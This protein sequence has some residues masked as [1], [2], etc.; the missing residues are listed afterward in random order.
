MVLVGVVAKYDTA[1]RLNRKVAKALASKVG[2]NAAIV[3]QIMGFFNDPA[4]N[5][6]PGAYVN[7]PTWTPGCAP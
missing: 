3:A 1:L 7:D 2:T 6:S 5:I 4:T